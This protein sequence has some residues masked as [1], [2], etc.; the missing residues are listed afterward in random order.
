[1]GAILA[2]LCG[3]GLRAPGTASHPP[4]PATEIEGQAATGLDGEPSVHRVEPVVGE[5][6]PPELTVTP[7]G[8]GSCP[9]SLLPLV[10]RAHRALP[11]DV[12]GPGFADY[13]E[14]TVTL[15]VSYDGYDLPVDLAGLS[16]YDRFDFSEAQTT[17]LSQNGFVV[18]PS[19]WPEFFSV[20]FD[21]PG[22]AN[23]VTTDSIYHVYHLLFERM[24]IDLE[25]DHFEPDVRALTAA[26]LQAAQALYHDLLGTELEEPARGALAY[27]AVADALIDPASAAPSEV[28]DLVEA[29]LARIEAHA[30]FGPSPIFSRNCPE[31]CDPCTMPPAEGCQGQPCLC[32]DYSQYVPR[33]HYT[34]SEQL[35]RYF[36]TMMWYGRINLR[37]G[38]DQETRT[39]LLITYILRNT[40][41]DGDPAARVWARVYDPTAFIV[42]HSDDLGLHQYGVLWDLVFG[43]DAPVSA[44]GDATDFRVF[45]EV[46]RRLPPPQINSLWVHIREDVEQATQGFRF[47]G[48]RFVLDSYIFDKL[49]QAQ[50]PGRMLPRGLDVMAA[51]GSGEA[52]AILDGMGETGYANYPEQMTKLRG[53]IS[54]LQADSWTQSLYWNWLYALDPLLEPKDQRYPAFMRT[55]AWTRRDLHAALGS[56]TELKHDT[57]LYAKQECPTGAPPDLPYGWV[58]PNPRAYA[59]LLALTR[60]TYDGLIDRGLLTERTEGNLTCLDSLLTFLLHASQRELAGEQ[61]S[62]ED[63]WRIFHYGFELEGLT[64]AAPN[65]EESEDVRAALVADVATSPAGEVLEE[66]TGDVFEIY[67]VVPDGSGGLHIA[68]GAVFS[69]YEFP[70][71]IDDRLTDEAWRAML[72]EGDAPDRPAWTSDFIAE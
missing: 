58:E 29:E 12:H 20:Y 22:L 30:G 35:R 13:T 40:A 65:A 59:R 24:L 69:Y 54:A 17:L 56:W 38:V 4:E 72:D 49:T 67:A 63:C 16:N 6:P 3:S 37:L 32:E 50:V 18:S 68:K 55:Q 44:I 21:N 11:A 42:G 27:F 1:L 46:A 57:I 47:M 61:L 39:A 5:V 36:Q 33:G 10:V 60:M 2:V 41:V 8:D 28:A 53:Q 26:C 64:L 45:V 48:Q 25:Q 34:R 7:G 9:P 14:I 70:W 23:L 62:S 71:P 43:P 19:Q 66:A 52:Y 15:P 31:G 51:L